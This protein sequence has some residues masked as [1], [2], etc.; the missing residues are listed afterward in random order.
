M[1]GSSWS[2]RVLSAQALG[3]IAVRG[4]PSV[5]S[6][7]AAALADDDWAVQKAAAKSMGIVA[8]VGDLF[9]LEALLPLLHDADWRVSFFAVAFAFSI[10]LRFPSSCVP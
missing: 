6:G 4:M 1:A 5:V 7:L 2:A 10:P 3:D 8:N 9:A